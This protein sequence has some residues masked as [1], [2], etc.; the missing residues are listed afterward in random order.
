M[1]RYTRTPVSTLQGINNELAKVELAMQDTLDRT[2]ST[3]NFMDANLDMNSRRILNLPL[4]LTDQEPLRRGDIPTGLSVSSQYVDDKLADAFALKIFQSPTA[5]GLTEIQTRTVDAGEVY[6]VRKTS[7]NSLA[8]IYSDAAGTI[9]I[10]QDGIDNKS[11]S[12]GVVE[13]FV[14]DGDYYVEVGSAKGG[15]LVSRLK[16]FLTVADMTSASYLSKYVEGTRIEWQGY[17]NQSDGGSNWGVL[18]FGAHTSDGGSIFS[19][20]SNTYVEAN[21]KN[22][23]PT[24]RKF[25][26]VGGG[27]YIS[28]TDII[29]T[30][31]GAKRRFGDYLTASDAI[32]KIAISNM[33]SLSDGTSIFD[34]EGLNYD[35]GTIPEKDFAIDFDATNKKILGR[36][37]VIACSCVE[38]RAVTIAAKNPARLV[39]EDLFFTDPNFDIAATVGGGAL[40]VGTYGIFLYTDESFSEAIT[41]DKVSIT[42][43]AYNC[44]G[45]VISDIT[46]QII[47]PNIEKYTISN[48]TVLG[49]VDVCYYGVSSIYGMKN[50]TTNLDCSD[51]RRGFIGYGQNGLDMEFTLTCSQGFGGSNAFVSLAC[52]GK[53]FGD[54]SGINVKGVV[55][56]F[57]G[58]ETIVG[59][60]HQGDEVE[61]SI[62]DVTSYINFK[63]LDGSGKYP[64]LRDLVAYR[65]IH[66]GSNGSPINPTS[67]RFEGFSLDYSKAGDVSGGAYG[68][69]TVPIGKDSMAISQRMMDEVGG[70]DIFTQFKINTSFKTIEFTPVAIGSSSAG[71][72][73]YSTSKGVVSISGGIMHYYISVG[74]SGHNG[75]GGLR[76]GYIPLLSLLLSS[77][78]LGNPPCS[79]SVSGFGVGDGV[80]S[81]APVGDM[82]TV[83]LYKT[84]LA[85]LLTVIDI[86]ASGFVSLSGSVP[87]YSI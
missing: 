9:E 24:P 79:L 8:T 10:V 68:V 51:V 75:V 45:W 48:V 2:G 61:G 62:S 56:G 6:E 38:G 82:S 54:V 17:Y 1:A 70:L 52:E 57:E 40:R 66:T 13:F 64:G 85:G 50:V 16:P 7:D 23:L 3:P 77:E 4:P 63:N 14:S 15:L 43:G 78:K 5:G 73:T 34:M 18:K 65:F 31:E 30:T 35:F 19:I 36:G 60:Y 21:F 76:L 27:Y 67:R 74:W 39:V 25:G 47:K 80:I 53:T 58:H 28:A 11:G 41:C 29:G 86:P 87:L 72:A 26:A 55:S 44:M 69:D 71:T 33:L 81:A 46:G 22:T 59:F 84:S 32:D 49:S 20:D 42:G 37:A 12:D 83:A